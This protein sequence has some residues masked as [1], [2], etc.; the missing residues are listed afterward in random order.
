MKATIEII[1]TATGY[2]KP[3]LRGRVVNA[4]EREV[5]LGASLSRQTLPEFT[6]EIDGGRG[7][8]SV[9]EFCQYGRDFV[10]AQ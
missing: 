3:G 9:R 5:F 10:F 8:K 6:L 7:K 4:G 2:F 1:T